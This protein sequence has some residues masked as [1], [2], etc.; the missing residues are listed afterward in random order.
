VQACCQAKAGGA[1]VQACQAKARCLCLRCCLCPSLAAAACHPR[2][3]RLS[4]WATLHGQERGGLVA[5]SS[6]V[7]RRLVLGV[8]M[9]HA[10]TCTMHHAPTHPLAPML[11]SP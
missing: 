9:H 5:G 11:C 1:E 4:F 7:R 2:S 6:T 3:N 10:P 8:I